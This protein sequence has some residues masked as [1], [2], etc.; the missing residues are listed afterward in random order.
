MSP[1]TIP[2]FFWKGAE[3]GL[4]SLEA[5]LAS[6]APERKKRMNEMY[7]LHTHIGLKYKLGR[8]GTVLQVG[9]YTK[10]RRCALV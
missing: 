3:S 9:T 2:I 1:L 10:Y 5:Q 7:V 4:E 8:D 6:P